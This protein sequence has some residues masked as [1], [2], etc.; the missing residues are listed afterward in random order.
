MSLRIFEIGERY[1]RLTVIERRDTATPRV[2]CRCDC[3]TEVSPR[4]DNLASGRS[5]SCGCSQRG[6]GNHRWK[7]NPGAHP[8]YSTWLGMKERCANPNHKAYARYGGRGITVCEQWREDFWAFVADMGDRPHG[9]TLDRIDN[10]GN[11][12]PGNVRWA[13]PSE[14]NLNQNPRPLQTHCDSGHE[15]TPENT[16]HNGRGDRACRT[17]DRERAQTYR[18]RQAA[19]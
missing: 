17:C 15:Y 19:L 10:D 6:E 3:G 5:A 13:T 16:R 7:G 18:E 14:Q 9:T 4:V 8:L 11:Y 1:G 2:L 12:E